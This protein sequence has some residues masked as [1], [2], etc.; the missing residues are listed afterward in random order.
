MGPWHPACLQPYDI[1][2]P[3][4]GFLVCDEPAWHCI[5][6]IAREWSIKEIARNELSESFIQS[7]LIST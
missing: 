3:F 2:I 7:M 5:F 6:K 4:S 1:L